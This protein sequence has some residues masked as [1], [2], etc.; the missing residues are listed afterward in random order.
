M[1]DIVVIKESRKKD[2]CD[3]H[4]IAKL[5]PR[6]YEGAALMIAGG[7]GSSSSG[8]ILGHIRLRRAAVETAGP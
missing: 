5:D 8:G 3:L 4:N 6:L 2:S 7:D 1:D